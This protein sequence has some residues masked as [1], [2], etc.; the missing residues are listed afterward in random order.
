MSYAIFKRMVK[1]VLKKS[2]IHNPT[3][4]FSNVDGKYA[5]RVCDI[6]I[7]GCNGSKRLYTAWGSG[8]LA[9]IPEEVC[10]GA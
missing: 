6:K 4:V 8:H 5:A 1:C 9:A 7:T 2:K 10:F 3:V